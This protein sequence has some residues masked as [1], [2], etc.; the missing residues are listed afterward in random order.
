MIARPKRGVTF[1]E[2]VY[3]VQEQPSGKVFAR[4]I[5]G[6]LSD[7]ELIF[8]NGIRVTPVMDK[9]A[10]IWKYGDLITAGS[11]EEMDARLEFMGVTDRCAEVPRL[12]DANVQE[13][14][15]T[16]DRFLDFVRNMNPDA[17]EEAGP[18]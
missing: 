1:R 3:V 18:R 10:Y 7:A 2:S 12:N 8:L 15:E 4:E 11:R 6:T 9:T 17:F 13:T 14:R 16:A 5:V